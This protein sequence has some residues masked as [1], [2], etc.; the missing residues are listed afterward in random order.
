MKYIATGGNLHR[1]W[2]TTSFKHVQ[3]RQSRLRG[4]GERLS[5]VD[6]WIEPVSTRFELDE[7]AR[8]AFIDASIDTDCSVVTVGSGAHYLSGIDSQRI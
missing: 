8:S 7:K 2:L 4:C 6:V 1:L 3:I 5:S